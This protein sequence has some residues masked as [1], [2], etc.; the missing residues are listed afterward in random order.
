M[1]LVKY[2]NNSLSNVTAAAG[3]G[4]SGGDKMDVDS[5]TDKTNKYKF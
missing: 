1:A 5:E 4:S 3:L 2:N